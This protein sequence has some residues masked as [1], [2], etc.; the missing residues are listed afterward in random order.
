MTLPGW[1][2][3]AL[4]ATGVMNV[5]AAFAFAPSGQALRALAGFPDGE[6]LYLATSSLFVLLFGVGYLWSAAAGR[7]DRIFITI[8]AVG[9]LSFVAL[10][11]T[12]WLARALPARAVLV[13]SG[14]VVF[15]VLF[16]AWLAGLG[17]PEASTHAA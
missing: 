2:R 4:W 17:V 15:G 13:A 16:L 8:A 14:D 3:N 9:K 12:Y 6:P 7:A 10:V 5:G 1:M 11:V